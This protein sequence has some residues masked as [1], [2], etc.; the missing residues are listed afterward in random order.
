M[1]VKVV[2][3]VERHLAMKRALAYRPP[4][5]LSALWEPFHTHQ[6]N[7]AMSTQLTPIHPQ[8]LRIFDACQ[9]IDQ[10]FL[11]C[12]GKLERDPGILIP[13]TFISDYI[14]IGW[15]ELVNG[16]LQPTEIG[17]AVAIHYRTIGRT[18]R[19]PARSSPET[20]N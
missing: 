2:G 1:V 16:L 3:G 18:L 8:R 20:L 12:L 4:K 5:Y 14:E 6:G 19:A 17:Q 15:I 10:D 9:S 7:K 11:S 13:S